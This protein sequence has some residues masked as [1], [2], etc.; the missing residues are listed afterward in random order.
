MLMVTMVKGGL[1]LGRRESCSDLHILGAR[2]TTA[3]PGFGTAGMVIRLIQ[4]AYPSASAEP[5]LY[6]SAGGS[7]YSASVAAG[8][9][10]V[11]AQANSYSQQCPNTTLVVVGYSQGAQIIDDA[12]CGGPDGFSLNTTRESVSVG[13]SRMTAAIVLMGSPRNV[14]GRLGNFG[15][16]TAGGFAARPLGYRCPAFE[17]IIRSYCDEADLY[18]AKG[19]SSATHQSYGRVYGQDAL[20]FVT[21]KLSGKLAS[22]AART[23]SNIML[24]AM[25]SITVI[26]ILL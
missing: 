5:I 9:R 6:P 20:D 11:A 26:L 25:V 7:M 2:E 12:F 16:A 21:Q 14:P 15:N 18:C 23:G 4:R 8:I 17:G 1:H 3:P 24:I 19:N 10:A 22:D 13:V